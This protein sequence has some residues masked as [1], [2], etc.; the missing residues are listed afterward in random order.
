MLLL[1]GWHMMRSTSLVSSPI[2]RTREAETLTG[3]F[4]VENYD[5]NLNP[6]IYYYASPPKRIV[7]MWQNSIETLLAFGAGD[8]II[9]ASGVSSDSVLSES[10]IS[11]YR[12][13]PIRSPQGLDVET[14][15]MLEPDLI[16][17]W[18]FDFTGRSNGQGRSDFWEKRGTNIYM[19]TVN[20]NEYK[21]AH[22]LFDEIRFIRDMAVFAGRKEAAQQIESEIE[23]AF[24]HPESGEPSLRVV[25]ISVMERGVHIYTPRTL[26]GD[27][28]QRLGA[29]VL[30]KE[31]ER[32]GEDEAI[33]YEELL[34]MDP[35][36]IF[37]QNQR[38]G[39]DIP[40]E[41]IYHH[42]A[43]QGL[44]AVRNHRVYGVPFFMIRCPGIRILDGI[45]LFRQGLYGV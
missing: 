29:E 16:V 36:I 4:T 10:S 37:I 8:R 34:I 18:L 6:H 1:W 7:A 26:P 13:I 21:A 11:A 17:G 23:A 42:P 5:S 9:A 14:L 15:L 24:H 31:I 2:E 44:K 32:I 30:G 3:G 35:D 40:Q 33:S 39:D 12:Q 20:M 25:V 22:T 38:L 27:L 28:L 41:K 45:R 43:L 19:T